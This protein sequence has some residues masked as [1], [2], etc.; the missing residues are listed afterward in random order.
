METYAPGCMSRL[1]SGL[2]QSGPDGS[3][4]R[5]SQVRGMLERGGEMTLEVGPMRIRIDKT[6]QTT[7]KDL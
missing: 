2:G 7:V 1:Y 6:L 3:A 4:S 5:V